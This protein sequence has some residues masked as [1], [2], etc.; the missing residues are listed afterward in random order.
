[1]RWISTRPA[2]PPP[3]PRP[4]P[5]PPH[6]DQHNYSNTSF[7]V[8]RGSLLGHGSVRA[9]RGRRSPSSRGASG[10]ERQEHNKLTSL[11]WASM[12]QQEEGAS[13]ERVFKVKASP[14]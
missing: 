9:V 12:G 13:G 8:R 11:R 14:P 6:R 10:E 3:P 4:P 2:P 7:T 1:M 5:P